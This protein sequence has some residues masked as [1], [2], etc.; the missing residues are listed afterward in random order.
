[1]NQHNN[2]D[3][4]ENQKPSRSIF[5]YLEEYS[6]IFGKTVEYC[7]AKEPCPRRRLAMLIAVAGVTAAFPMALLKVDI[8]IIALILLF[9]YLIFVSSL[10]RT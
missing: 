5:Q 4:S 1:M 3:D 8:S 2:P 9:L 7:I 6:K 10:T